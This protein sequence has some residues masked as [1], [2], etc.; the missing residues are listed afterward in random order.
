M[1]N[2]SLCAARRSITSV[3]NAAVVTLVLM[4][5]STLSPVWAQKA[6]SEKSAAPAAA[7]PAPPSTAALAATAP[8]VLSPVQVGELSAVPVPA[9]AAKAWITVDV[10]SGQIVA[11]SN[12]DMKIEPASLT[13]IMTAYVAFTAI[14]EKR[15]SLE[16]QANVSQL[17]WKTR[18]SRM[19]IEPRKPV[20][21]DELLKGVIIQSGNDASVA[22]AEAVS[23]SESAFVSVMNEEARRMGMTNT[24]F[25]N[26]TGL[27]DPQHV[28]TVR[29][30]ATIARRM[31]NDHPTYFPYY[32]MREFTYNKIKQSNRNRL[33]WA[34]PSVDGMKTGHTDAAGYCLVA[35]AKRGDR[36]VITVLVGSDSMATRAEESLK[37]LNWTFQN[38]ETVKLFDQTHA[39]VEAQV[40]QGKVDTTKLGVSEPLWVTVPRGKAGE[41][42]TIAKRPDPL[43]APL[44]KDERVGTLTLMLDNKLLLT[45]PLLVLE[46]VERAGFVGR[47]VDSVKLWFRKKPE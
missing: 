47:T 39:A 26:T 32:A 31:I 5:A 35:T 33:L 36:R 4:I 18:G 14:K 15:L 24:V 23:G 17:A 44:A 34:D 16:Q 46:P 1:L 37:L 12:P 25:M 2:H 43:L 10:T 11:A 20:T 21:V 6:S 8:S 45:R 29:D 40:W 27:P 22:L 19:F 3:A 13:K 42:K 9:I 7:A 38:F 28:T 41:V 30:L